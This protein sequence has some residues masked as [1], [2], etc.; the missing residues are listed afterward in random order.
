[1]GAKEN[2]PEHNTDWH[3]YRNQCFHF[4]SLFIPP[5]G[6]DR[7]HPVHPYFCKG[8][9]SFTNELILMSLYRITTCVWLSVHKLP[10]TQS[11]ENNTSS[12]FCIFIWFMSQNV[13]YKPYEFQL[14]WYHNTW[15]FFIHKQFSK[16]PNNWQTWVTLK[17]CYN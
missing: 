17:T 11:I 5:A 15:V 8:N 7:N 14:R 12:I 9:F 6:I 2:L 4:Q 3:S 1:M 16:R 13:I 10:C